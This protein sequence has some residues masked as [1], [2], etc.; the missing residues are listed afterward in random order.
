MT[1]EK[2]LFSCAAS[3]VHPFIRG[4]VIATLSIVKWNKQTV[5]RRGEFWTLEIR[6][7]F[8]S[9]IN[10]SSLA[11][12][13]FKKRFACPFSNILLFYF[14]LFQWV[15]PVMDNLMCRTITNVH[16]ICHFTT[17]RKKWTSSMLSSVVEGTGRP[18]IFLSFKLAGPFLNIPIQWQKLW[19][20]ETLAL[21]YDERPLCIL[22]PTV[23]KGGLRNVVLLFNEVNPNSAERTDVIT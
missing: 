4:E 6:W 12:I 19:R 22:G 17:R 15:L 3:H 23:R 9:W 2:K 10:V 1:L 13:R 14:V 20:G 18:S 7:C 11:L 21:Y 8:K 5:I 16:V